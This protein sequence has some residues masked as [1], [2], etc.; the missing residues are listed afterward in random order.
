M[1]QKF[2]MVVVLGLVVASSP[3]FAHLK[4]G[5]Y[6]GKKADTESCSFEVKAVR[7][8]GMKHPLNERVDVL[9]GS[10]PFVLSHAPA[11]SVEKATVLFDGVHLSGAKGVAGGGL[12]AVLTMSHEEGHEGPVEIAMIKHDYKDATKSTQWVCMG[13]EFQAGE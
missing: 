10:E 2:S 8:E 1:F 6:V 4:I 3:S 5:K 11:V 7:F 12:G 13:L 9:M